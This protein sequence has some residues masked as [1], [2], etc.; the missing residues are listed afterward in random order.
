MPSTAAAAFWYEVGSD[1]LFFTRSQKSSQSSQWSRCFV[2]SHSLVAVSQGFVLKSV[3]K[4]D[5]SFNNRQLASAAARQQ[6]AR[7]SF[8]LYVVDAETW[9]LVGPIDMIVNTVS[10]FQPFPSFKTYI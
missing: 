2:T 3:P 10:P 9:S 6:R 4:S 1:F 5:A 7:D 8:Q